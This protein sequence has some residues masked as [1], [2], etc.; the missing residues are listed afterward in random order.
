MEQRATSFCFE[1]CIKSLYHFRQMNFADN[2][3]EISLL[4]KKCV[5]VTTQ[6]ILSPNMYLKRLF[7]NK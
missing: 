5:V 6:R 4:W 3:T 7:L 2:E 1:L